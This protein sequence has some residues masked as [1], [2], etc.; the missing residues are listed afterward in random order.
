MTL[1]YG[2]TC[3]QRSQ[4]L[5]RFGWGNQL[6]SGQDTSVGKTPVSSLYPPSIHCGLQYD[7]DRSTI[8]WLE[9]V[10]AKKISMIRQPTKT[11]LEIEPSGYHPT[12][13]CL[14]T[15]SESACCQSPWFLFVF[16]LLFAV[17]WI[18]FFHQPVFPDGMTRLYL[19]LSVFVNP[20]EFVQLWFDGSM[21]QG[22]ILDRT[23]IVLVATLIIAASFSLGRLI[24]E[25]CHVDR[26]FTGLE[27]FL[28]S[29]GVGG[30]S[31]SLG[32]L[33][34]GA[35]GCLNRP[36][37]SLILF[38]LLLVGVGRYTELFSVLFRPIKKLE[39]RATWFTNKQWMEWLPPLLLWSALPFFGL[40]LLGSFLPPIDFD[41][42]EYHL[43]VPK[44]WYLQGR[45]TFLPHN[46]YGNMPMGAEMHSLLAMVLM[47]GDDNW[48][49]GALAGKTIISLFAVFGAMSL[50]AAGKRFVSAR[51]GA[52]AAAVYIS[53][54]WV[55]HVSMNGLVE[56]VWGFYFFTALYVVLIWI[57]TN[58]SISERSRRGLIIV[59]GLLAGAAVS[60]K[61]L[62]VPLVV[63]PIAGF[64]GLTKRWKH[65]IIGETD[66][67]IEPSFKTSSGAVVL[68]LFAAACSGGP[69]FIKNACWSGNPT[70]PLL[71]NVFD[72]ETRNP[73][74]HEQWSKAHEP[75]GFTW[76]HLVDD[77]FRMTFSSRWLSPLILPMVLFALM[78][79][80][81]HRL[82]C[83]LLLLTC[84]YGIV[85]WVFTNRID[86]F[87]VPAFPLLALVA[88]IGTTYVRGRWA[89][90]A[91]VTVIV[92]GLLS[93]GI[94][95]SSL[96]GDPRF[97][98]PL[99]SLVNDETWIDPVHRYLNSSQF[100]GE[101]VLLV[102]D[103]EPFD[104]RVPAL[105]NT[106]FDDSI[107]EHLIREKTKYQ[108]V[109]AF[110]E[111][112]ITHVY[113]DWLEIERY[114]N[115]YGFSD[116]VHPQVLDELV[117]DQVLRP[118]PAW[119]GWQRSNGLERIDS[120]YEVVF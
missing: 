48:W 47:P 95:F 74:K 90:N 34:L 64:I 107:F 19:L 112:G 59:A 54:P 2:G 37:I 120:V 105:Y 7:T 66:Q 6:P 8:P 33:L 14:S 49:W 70:Y 91:V 32:M 38:S 97:F 85:W 36:F 3:F 17:Y 116:F 1:S 9:L 21:I 101:K 39:Q 16:L 12:G 106:C 68:F 44:E 92:V 5:T 40:I 86:R 29:V 25:L 114:R 72:G 50:Y 26:L 82:I 30:N 98:V 35:V 115:T 42:R 45:I 76:K 100:T 52:V 109:E 63:I 81:H 13:R 75:P 96:V 24:L 89:W 80:S 84:Y 94:Y 102:G 20:L 55:G 118:D 4:V 71:Y 23:P 83:L 31:L 104:L 113:L 73:E 108:Q 79:G 22:E 18:Y 87:W 61:Y 119:E 58:L 57:H 56:A 53:I 46:V 51:A 43:Q 103:A 77:G 93:N 110:R 15:Q 67:V 65:L 88:G 111:A 28:L 69:W 11:K 62:S 27:R 117:R 41:V 60:C 78:V 10:C 99:R